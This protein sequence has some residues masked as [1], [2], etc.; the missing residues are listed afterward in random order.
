MHEFCFCGQV[1]AQLESRVNLHADTPGETPSSDWQQSGTMAFPAQSCHIWSSAACWFCWVSACSNRSP[2]YAVF[3]IINFS[4]CCWSN[5]GSLL[6][7]WLDL[8]KQ[9]CWELIFQCHTGISQ[10]HQ[11]AHRCLPTHWL[12]VSSARKW[13]QACTYSNVTGTVLSY[14]HTTALLLSFQP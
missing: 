5:K 13:I 7:F 6:C 14:K 12:C 9:I 11:N 2:R 4:I 10:W 3:C 8:K 1:A